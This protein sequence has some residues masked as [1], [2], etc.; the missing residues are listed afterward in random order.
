MHRFIIAKLASYT[1]DDAVS[2]QYT[3]YNIKITKELYYRTSLRVC[4]Q[5]VKKGTQTRA[6]MFL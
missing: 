3:L 2:F 4:C 6:K 5:A 1:L